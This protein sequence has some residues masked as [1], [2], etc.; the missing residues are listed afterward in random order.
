MK[1]NTAKVRKI[2]SGRNALLLSNGVPLTGFKMLSG[3]ESICKR[4]SS[5]AISTRCS[6]VS[7]RPR[8]P[9]EHTRIPAFCALS[10]VNILSS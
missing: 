1:R 5:N 2:S 9:P 6:N 8:M 4:L 10:M 3:T 7:L